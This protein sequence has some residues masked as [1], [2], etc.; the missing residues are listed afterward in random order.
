M[1]YTF[2]LVGIS[3]FLAVLIAGDYFIRTYGGT[4][5]GV[6][7]IIFL[8]GALAVAASAPNKSIATPRLIRAQG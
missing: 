8:F 6:G 5:A 7:R 4:W 1:I 3:A 2:A